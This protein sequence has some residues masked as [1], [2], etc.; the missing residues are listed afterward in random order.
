MTTPEG[1]VVAAALHYLQ[2]RGVFCWR[3]N[4]GSYKPEGTDRFIKYGYRGSADILGIDVQGRF[5]AVECKAGKGK[6]S[7]YQEAFLEEIRR[8]GGVGIVVRDT[9]WQEV[10]DAA[11]SHQKATNA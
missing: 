2:F 4:T 9:D 6:L 10:I 7:S 11:L 5:W 8:R 1:L 3:N